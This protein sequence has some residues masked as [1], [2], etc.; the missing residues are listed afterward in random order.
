[1]AGNDHYLFWKTFP[2]PVTFHAG[3]RPVNQQPFEVD[4]A[5]VEYLGNPARKMRTGKPPEGI[6]H[7]DIH[8]LAYRLGFP[9][10]PF[11]PEVLV[12]NQFQTNSRW[13][14]GRLEQVFVPAFKEK[15]ADPAPTMPPPAI[16]DHYACYR[17]EGEDHGEMFSLEDQ[18]GLVTFNV[19]HPIMFG[20]P[21]DKNGE[22]IIDPEVHLAIYELTPPHLPPAS[23]AVNTYDQVGPLSLNC[24]QTAWL[25]VPSTMKKPG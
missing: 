21:I 1:M 19:L 23:Y 25:A 10:P 3:I 8:L 17:A 6:Y 2:K 7:P 12:T 16:V 9:P 14:L 5:L 15:D 24:T 20:F 22:G 13:K 18:F 11:I 4:F